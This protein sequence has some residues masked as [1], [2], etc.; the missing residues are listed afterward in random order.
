MT[1]TRANHRGEVMRGS[2]REGPHERGSME[3]TRKPLNRRAYGSIPHFQTSRLGPGDHHIHS[4]QERIATL[5]VR[6]KKDRVIVT[7]KLDGS[8]VAIALIDGEVTG[9]SRAGYRVSNSRYYFQ[10]YFQQWLTVHPADYCTRLLPILEQGI[11]V[12]AE[13]LLLAHGTRYELPH[14]PLVI[15]DCTRNGKRLLF[16]RTREIATNAGIPHATVLSDGPPCT[17]QE[18]TALLGRNGHHGADPE[19]GPEGAVW[20]V[21]RGGVFDFIAKWVNPKKIDGRYLPELAGQGSVYN[22]YEKPND[23]PFL[24]L[25]TS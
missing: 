21:E 17:V 25:P 1:A 20:R 23:N 14:C 12:H 18:A 24:V 7:E 16:D 6:D 13:W 4:G 8:N 22:D 11:I 19:E 10:R 5:K 15:F 9:I 2:P 3:E